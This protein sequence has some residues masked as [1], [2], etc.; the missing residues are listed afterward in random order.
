MSDYCILVADAE[1]ARI[2][3]LE[4]AA[5]PNAESS[6]RLV[7]QQMDFVN[8]EE[9]L[10]GRELWGDTKSEG[11]SYSAAGKPHGYDDHR[12]RQQERHRHHFAKQVVA[13]T[14][15]HALDHH[16]K[17]LVIAAESHMLG[18]LRSA[19]DLPARSGIKVIEVAKDLTTFSPRQIHE[20]LA[21][22]KIIPPMTRPGT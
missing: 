11:R 1:R 16:V 2:F 4:A 19:I 13:Q 10:P 12:E 18:V 14:I 22:E 8:P 6:P 3:T 20:H 7:E 17:H 15:R 5:F 9:A 21:R